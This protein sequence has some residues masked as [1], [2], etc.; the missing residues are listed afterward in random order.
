V[1]NYSIFASWRSETNPVSGAWLLDCAQLQ[2]AP[3]W[4]PTKAIMQMLFWRKNVEDGTCP[5]P[6]LFA[7]SGARINFLCKIKV[8]GKFFLRKV[9]TKILH[10][11]VN[12][13]ACL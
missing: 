4:E 8:E 3:Y 11:N 5:S 2:L 1:S 9:T 10:F 12:F 7:A 13:S 6:G